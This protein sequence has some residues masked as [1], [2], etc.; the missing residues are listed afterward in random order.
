MQ[1]E[2]LT[3]WR[4]VLLKVI[5]TCCGYDHLVGHQAAHRAVKH[6]PAGK[7]SEWGIWFFFFKSPIQNWVLNIYID[8]AYGE[9]SVSSQSDHHHDHHQ[10]MF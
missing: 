2:N 3:A 7:P 8:I 1:W 5:E 10:W 9:K 4:L 6:T